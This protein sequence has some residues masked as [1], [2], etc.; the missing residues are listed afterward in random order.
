M[1]GDYQVISYSEAFVKPNSRTLELVPP[2]TRINT[3][4]PSTLNDV[5]DQDLR[6]KLVTGRVPTTGNYRL[7]LRYPGNVAAMR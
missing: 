1:A 6:R 3:V 2:G 5:T 4:A 7:E